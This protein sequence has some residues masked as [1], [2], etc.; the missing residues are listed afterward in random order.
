MGS[1]SVSPRVLGDN[2]ARSKTL[3]M[4]LC[5]ACKECIISG[6]M[7]VVAKNGDPTRCCMFT[8]VTG[9]SVVS[10]NALVPCLSLLPLKSYS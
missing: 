2:G 10:L 6:A 3:L 9:S 8:R 1:F 7:A 4:L 5:E